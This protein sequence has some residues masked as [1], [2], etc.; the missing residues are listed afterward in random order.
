MPE[1]RRRAYDV[2]AVIEALA[3]TASVLELR[4]EAVERVENRGD[5]PVRVA[6]SFFRSDLFADT[7]M[8]QP[9]FVRPTL[10]A[11]LNELVAGLPELLGFDPGPVVPGGF[12]QGGTMALGYAL[13][14]PG[15]VPAVLNFSGFVPSHPDV[16]VAPDTVAGT[17][18]WWGHGTED[19]AVP[20]QLAVRG[21]EA[22]R[23]AGARIESGAEIGEFA[24]VRA[25]A[26]VP[27]NGFVAP[28]ADYNGSTVSAKAAGKNG[29]V[30]FEPGMTAAAIRR[31]N[32]QA[33][34]RRA[35]DGDELRLL[36]HPIVDLASGR[37]A[38][39]EALVRL[40]NEDGIIQAPGGFIDLATELGLIDELTP[41]AV[42]EA[43]RTWLPEGRYVRV[44]L[45]PAEQ[46][47]PE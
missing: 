13:Q 19:P 7:R 25:G 31:L 9:E 46:A 45:L 14:N 5:V 33:D 17:A 4:A 42:R 3:D 29:V 27:R 18:F 11:A 12:S 37:L 8:N 28:D 36:Y 16:E 22:L 21:R 1:N 44:S 15:A 34:L 32:L 39:V 38:G 20:H 26:V 6:T 30:T 35:I 40:Y 24:I 2:R 47:A 43:A 23:E 10:Q 41:Q